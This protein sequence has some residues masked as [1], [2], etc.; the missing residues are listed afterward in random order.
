MKTA[1]I[2]GGCFWCMEAIFRDIKGVERVASGFSGGTVANPSYRQVCG[3]TTGHAEV[4]Q[5]TFDP[6]VISYKEI[7]DIFFSIHD[8]TTP[9]R[10]GPDTGRQYRSIILYHDERQRKTAESVIR[11][12]EAAHAWEAPIVTE[13][14]PF[15]VFYAAE[16]YH[17]D[18]FENNPDQPYC[19]AVVA[20]KV[21]K[22]RK[23]HALRL[24]GRAP[25]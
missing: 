4:L 8:P 10:Q 7:L 6:S 19:R 24:K 12:L 1:T 18:F 23:A 16:D 21:A 3:G 9:D 20:P 2:G 13:V 15:E 5:V 17:Q 22:F 14:V 11:D 25:K